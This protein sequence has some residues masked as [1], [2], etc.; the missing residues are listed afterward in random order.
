MQLL[1]FLV[2]F[3]FGLSRLCTFTTG[4]QCLSSISI[5]GDSP[6]SDYSNPEC[7]SCLGVLER[8]SWDELPACDGRNLSL[9]PSE[10]TTSDDR[11]GQGQKTA[12]T[13]DADPEVLTRHRPFSDT[14]SYISNHVFKPK[15]KKK[16]SVVGRC[17]TDYI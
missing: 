1:L 11:G 13:T 15:V 3:V 9:P 17:E 8:T 16:L 12:D 10:F 14:P 4:N 7:S 2:G 5:Q 6:Y